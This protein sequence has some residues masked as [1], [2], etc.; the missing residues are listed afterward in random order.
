MRRNEG[1]ARGTVH[2]SNPHHVFEVHPAWG[3]TGQ[4][5][6]FERKDLVDSMPDF[7]GFGASKFKPLFK[8]MSDGDWPLAF[9]EGN[10]LHVKLREASNFFQ[11]PVRVR[12][13]RNIQG[14]HEVTV[15]V[16]SDRSFHNKVFEG[17]RCI[18][19]EG[20]PV[21]DTLGVGDRLFLLGIFSVNL[22]KAL[23]ASNNAHS[24]VEAV[25]VADA[26]EFFVFGE[27]LKRAVTSCTN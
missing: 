15:D 19:V 6:S 12:E 11:L 10:T 16:F 21:D 18:T 24:E 4:G 9:Q 22:R 25:A 17:L 1:H 13:V 2:P 7:R 26:V 3:F 20:S 8:S 23:E 14:G 27:A 5:V